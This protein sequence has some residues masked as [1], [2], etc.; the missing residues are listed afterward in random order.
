MSKKLLCNLW[1]WEEPAFPFQ[2]SRL[3]KRC[4]NSVWQQSFLANTV[5]FQSSTL[6]LSVDTASSKQWFLWVLFLFYYHGKCVATQPTASYTRR[7]WEV[8]LGKY[9]N[10]CLFIVIEIC[11]AVQWNTAPQRLWLAAPG[12]KTSKIIQISTASTV[13]QAFWCFT[14]DYVSAPTAQECFRF[15]VFSTVCV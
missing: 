4:Q 8:S 7:P 6:L 1:Q 9:D 14:Q 12:S 10:W 11:S 3:R 15:C 2:N 13:I 5:V